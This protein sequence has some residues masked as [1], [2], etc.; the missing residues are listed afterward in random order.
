METKITGYV[1]PLSVVNQE[2]N[3]GE[4]KQMLNGCLVKSTLASKAERESGEFKEILPLFLGRA[5]ESCC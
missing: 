5:G 3:G 2:T 1:L 4:P